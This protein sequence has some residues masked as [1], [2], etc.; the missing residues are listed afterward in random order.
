MLY[1]VDI[2]SAGKL[3]CEWQ[4]EAATKKEAKAIA[5]A[6]AMRIYHDQPKITA[7]VMDWNHDSNEGNG[8]V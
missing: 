7:K 8:R 5:L 2:F 1:A 4:R 3:L 6:D